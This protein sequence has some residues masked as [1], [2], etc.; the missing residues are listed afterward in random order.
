M[1]PAL[2]NGQPAECT[3]VVLEPRGGDNGLAV[4]PLQ[5]GLELRNVTAEEFLPSVRPWVRAVGVVMVGSFVTSLGLMAV[6]PYRVVVRGMGQIRPSSETS[7]INAPFAGRVLTLKVSSN[8]NVE[9]GQVIAELDPADLEGKRD[10][11]AQ[12]QNAM[13]RERQAVRRRSN[14][15]VEGAAQEVSKAQAALR[16]A[17]TEHQRY[18]QL[19]AS[20]AIAPMQLDEKQANLEVA[21]SNLA[22]TRQGVNELLSSQQAELSQLD[23]EWAASAGEGGQVQRNLGIAIVRAPVSGVLHSL[24]LRNPQQV[25]AAGMELAR[26]APSKTDLVA[27]VLVRSEDIDHLDLGQRADLR[28]TGCPYPDFGTLKARVSSIAPD[29]RPDQPQIP[30]APAAGLPAAQASA[31]GGYEVTLRPDSTVLQSGNRQCKVKLG[32]D[33]TADVTTRLETVLSFVMRKAR[34]ISGQ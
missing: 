26:I 1:T 27:K 7:V 21:R 10:E 2:Q 8:Q 33:L 20:G 34:L 5:A 28:I 4:Q 14:A 29:A 15:A 13:E 32:M 6:W 22:K 31:G 19:V 3:R 12:R 16:L 24:S 17:E 9:R 18:S 25:V 11:L 30:G 23:K